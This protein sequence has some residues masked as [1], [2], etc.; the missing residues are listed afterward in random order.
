MI[1]PSQPIHGFD[2]PIRLRQFIQSLNECVSAKKAIEVEVDPTYS[3]DDH[4]GGR[5]FKDVT[6][7]RIWRLVEPSLGFDGVWEE[8][9]VA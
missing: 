2:T 4:T 3:E 8:A 5:W 6:T 9:Y 7:G 1:F